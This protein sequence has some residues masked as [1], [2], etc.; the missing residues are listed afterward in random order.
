M[1]PPGRRQGLDH[2]DPIDLTNVGGPTNVVDLTIESDAENHVLFARH[3]LA[4]GARGRADHAQMPRMSSPKG[5]RTP[6]SRPTR[7]PRE[8]A[9]QKNLARLQSG[10][11]VLNLD[12]EIEENSPSVVPGWIDNTDNQYGIPIVGQASARLSEKPAVGSLRTTRA[13]VDQR[14]SLSSNGVEAARQSGSQTN[15][16]SSQISV[17]PDSPANLPERLRRST[18]NTP[19]AAAS[20]IP[21]ANSSPDLPAQ[22]QQ[23]SA[24]VTGTKSASPASPRETEKWNSSLTSVRRT[25]VRRSPLTQEENI[26]NI[27]DINVDPRVTAPAD[28]RMHRQA[29]APTEIAAVATCDNATAHAGLSKPSGNAKTSIVDDPE[30]D[31]VEA[32]H[33][34]LVQEITDAHLSKTRPRKRAVKT[35]LPM[36]NRG[37]RQVRDQ[38]ETTI[39]D[40]VQ[41]QLLQEASKTRSDTLVQK[42]NE[43]NLRAS[44]PRPPLPH[45]DW[46]RNLTDTVTRPPFFQGREKHAVDNIVAAIGTPTEYGAELPKSAK[47]H[48]IEINTEDLA[49]ARSAIENCFKIHTTRR[50]EQHAVHTASILWRQR[51]CL[52]RAGRAEVRAHEGA[53]LASLPRRYLQSA[54]PFA[55]LA[56]QQ[57]VAGKSTSGKPGRSITQDVF[58]KGNVKDQVTRSTWSAPVKMHASNSIVVPAFREYVSVKKSVLADNVSKLT[59]TPYHVGELEDAEVADVT[60]WREKLCWYFEMERENNNNLDLRH[61]QCRFFEHTVGVIFQEIG[62]TWGDVLY[63][64][65]A[66]DDKIHALNSTRP[67]S[68]DFKDV[69]F[70]RSAH[71]N[72]TFQRAGES[73]KAVLFTPEDKTWSEYLA[74]RHT[75]PECASLRLA[76]LAG[77]LFLKEGK[78][79]IWYLAFQ[80]E[81]MRAFLSRKT[82]DIARAAQYSY[83]NAACRICHQHNCILHGEIKQQLGAAD[84]YESEDSDE[85]DAETPQTP[86]HEITISGNPSD[87]DNVVMHDVEKVTNYKILV[88]PDTSGVQEDV[89]LTGF[90]G[91]KPPAGD[92]NAKWWLRA[93]NPTTHWE[94]RNPFVPCSHRGLCEEAYCRCFI[95][96]IT[97]EKSCSCASS[98]NRRFPGCG[99]T[100]TRKSGVCSVDTCLCVKFKRECDADLCTTCGATEILDPVNRYNQALQSDGCCNVAIQRRVPRKT[101]LGHSEL[102]GFGLYAGEDLKEDDYIGEYIGEIISAEEAE[103]REVVYASQNTMYLFSLNKRQEV[104]ATSVG[105]KLRFINNADDAHSNCSPKVVFCNTVFR[106]ALYAKVDIKAGA[107]LFF[108]Y[109]YD[110]KITA[111]FKQPQLVAV[112]EKVKKPNAKSRID[113]PLAAHSEVDRSKIIAAA[114]KAR[115]AKAEKRARLQA[116]LTVQSHPNSAPPQSGSTRARKST[117]ATAN[118]RVPSRVS[119]LW[120]SHRASS[121]DSSH[122]SDTPVEA[123]MTDNEKMISKQHATQAPASSRIIQETD[124]ED[125][126]FMP[127]NT[128][129]ES[130]EAA[131]VEDHGPVIEDSE[132]ERPRRRPGRHQRHLPTVVAVRDRGGARVGAGRTKRKR[133]VID[134]SDEE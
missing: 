37:P 53:S 87:D 122:A 129:E 48:P 76:A 14:T 90:K 52:E 26:E 12:D 59:F 71:C 67:N 6:L 103:R 114:A 93:S 109:N 28:S 125:H 3:S 4:N 60:H 84:V 42:K 33:S 2:N 121:L 8:Q 124:S 116:E 29:D 65:L 72:E 78:F 21:R 13:S 88:N 73:H 51:T 70:R 105:N 82:N 77:A 113:V 94:K 41:N 69:I 96:G 23:S 85:A 117:T 128:Q 31:E 101:L 112:K 63:W 108:N 20:G 83:R 45:P 61:E 55:K 107:E 110:P 66:P 75:E 24:S 80:S 118:T 47:A 15:E 36:K 7:L 68:A 102:H 100:C 46:S 30:Q 35:T 130:Q 38:V 58:S 119:R 111:G 40:F 49:M 79:S 54:S 9:R 16:D 44:S 99:S 64:L 5:S 95:Q 92:F 32:T 11:T 115:A 126:D 133:P 17:G 19:R 89:I 106:I 132:G 86:A 127:G 50:R 39:E 25:V 97:C 91:S 120:R 1:P 10:A 43:L 57:I 104:D 34:S 81:T 62:I 27:L 18:N 134:T 22:R 74:E 56:R 123:E 98:C 131:I